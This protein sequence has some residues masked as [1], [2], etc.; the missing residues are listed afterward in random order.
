M[1]ST[2]SAICCSWGD[3]RWILLNTFMSVNVASNFGMTMPVFSLVSSP[4]WMMAYKEAF[5]I[6]AMISGANQAA[7]RWLNK[8]SS[9]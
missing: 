1:T 3:T 9:K 7:I 4:C 8:T 2:L 6:S 5:N